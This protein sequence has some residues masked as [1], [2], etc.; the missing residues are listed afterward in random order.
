MKTIAQN[1]P[2]F[3]KVPADQKVP[4]PQIPA[5]I[6]SPIVLTNR[7]VDVSRM[8]PSGV[9]QIKTMPLVQNTPMHQKVPVAQKAP[10][11]QNITEIS[12]PTVLTNKKLDVS[13][14]KPS[15]VGQIETMP[16]VQIHQCTKKCQ[17]LKRRR[18]LKTQQKYPHQLY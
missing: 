9:G 3:Q 5:E 14:L 11:P 2:A 7:K 17:W 10:A 4:A 1:T 15:G 16:L 12:S 8:K 18:S 6:C 13:R